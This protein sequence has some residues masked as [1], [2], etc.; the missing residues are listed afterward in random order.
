MMNKY[1]TVNIGAILADRGGTQYEWTNC[2]VLRFLDKMINKG[3][4][5]LPYLY[6]IYPEQIVALYEY[7]GL[8]HEEI[9]SQIKTMMGSLLFT[10]K[11][12][13]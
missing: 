1:D 8:P 10:I 3:S 7:Y 6:L 12:E 2:W 13:Q 4:P 11:A 5:E 9:K